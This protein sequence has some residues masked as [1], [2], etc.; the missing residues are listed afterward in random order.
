VACRELCITAVIAPTNKFGLGKAKRNVKKGTARLPV[1][2]PN[3]GTLALAGKGVKA[4][5]GGANVSAT[6][7]TAPGTV[8]LRIKA[9]GKKRR[10]LEEAGKVKVKP[11]ITFTPTGGDARTQSIK[12]KLKK[13]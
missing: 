9:K 4:A 13:T 5:R 6:T 8:E 2:G 11:K 10:T 12:L 1:T 7:L 3:P